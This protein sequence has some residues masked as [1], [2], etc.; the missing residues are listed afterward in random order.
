[1]IQE[2][3]DKSMPTR[4]TNTQA[5]SQEEEMS[6]VL[7]KPCYKEKT[8]NITDFIGFF[9]RLKTANSWDDEKAAKAFPS[10]LESNSIYHSKIDGLTDVEKSPSPR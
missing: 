2:E 5:N 9:E 3:K 6:E 1:M 7:V 10:L 8:E 4:S